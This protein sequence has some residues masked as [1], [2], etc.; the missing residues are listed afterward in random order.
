MAAPGG[1]AGGCSAI[2]RLQ[3]AYPERGRVDQ[4][5]R[6]GSWNHNPRNCRSAYR[7]NNHPDNVNDNIGFRVCCLPQHPSPSEPVDGNRPGAH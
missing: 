7:N 2:C 6:G 3:R 1:W 4:L 5:L